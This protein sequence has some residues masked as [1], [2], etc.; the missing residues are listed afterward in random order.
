MKKLHCCG[1][2]VFLLCVINSFTFSI[3][4]KSIVR[5]T[6]KVDF[7]QPTSTSSTNTSVIDGICVWQNTFT[8]YTVQADVN[9]RNL[10]YFIAT[11]MVAI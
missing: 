8:C 2:G 4:S 9:R 11:S 10:R 6:F 5:A 3:S 1:I 7:L